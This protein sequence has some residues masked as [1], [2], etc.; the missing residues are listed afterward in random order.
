ME[1]CHRFIDPTLKDALE[2][3]G[4]NPAAVGDEMVNILIAAW[5]TMASTLTF[6][7]YMLSRHPKVLERLRTG[8]LSKVG[9]SR[10][11]T[12]DDVQGMKHM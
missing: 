1:V 5:D 11:P 2:T 10:R 8:V 4:Q 12:Y 3:N 6:L 9:S 7:I